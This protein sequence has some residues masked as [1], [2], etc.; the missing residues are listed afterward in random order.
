MSN[1]EVKFW[2]SIGLMSLMLISWLQYFTNRDVKSSL[3]KLWQQFTELDESISHIGSVEL[4]EGD[5][6]KSTEDAMCWDIFSPIN[7]LIPVNGQ[8]VITTNVKTKMH[9]CNALILSRSGLAAKARVSHRAGVIDAKFPDYWGVILVNEGPT[10]YQ[11]SAGDR[12]GQ[13]YFISHDDIEVVGGIIQD[14]V[15]SGG[16]G[17]T[18]K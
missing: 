11:V 9:G 7:V 12:I 8:V 16:F 10:P 18:G 1:E 17:S 13:V 14:Q 6:V 4:L 3:S 2:L 5:L 15:R